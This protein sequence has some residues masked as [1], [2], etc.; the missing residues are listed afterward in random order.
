MRKIN[1]IV[2]SITTASTLYL[3][4][5]NNDMFWMFLSGYAFC[6]FVQEVIDGVYGMVLNKRPK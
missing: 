2:S 1:L 6:M 3:G 5:N 4:I